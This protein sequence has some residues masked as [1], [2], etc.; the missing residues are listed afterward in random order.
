MTESSNSTLKWKDAMSLAS[1]F[2]PHPHRKGHQS[3]ASRPV[4]SAIVLALTLTVGMPIAAA[5]DLE[6]DQPITVNADNARL[7]EGQGIATYTLSLIHI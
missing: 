2:M 7:D 4:L 3:V 5:F 1:K 6:S